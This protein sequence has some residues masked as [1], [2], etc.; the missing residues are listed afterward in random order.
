MKKRVKAVSIAMASVVACSVLLSACSSEGG[1]SAAFLSDNVVHASSMDKQ[2]SGNYA[3]GS[4]GT[5]E[6][7]NASQSFKL[8]L[9]GKEVVLKHAAIDR[10]GEQY[11]PINEVAEAIGATV[12]V[13]NTRSTITLTKGVRKHVLNDKG[14]KFP[15][16][17]GVK[18][19]PIG[20]IA[21]GLYTQ[22]RY[23][24][25]EGA[26]YLTSV[27]TGATSQPQG[28]TNNGSTNKPQNST[29]SNQVGSSVDKANVTFKLYVDGKEVDLKHAP[30][31]RNG[32]QYFAIDEIAELIGAKVTVDSKRSLITITKGVKKHVLN[33]K[34][35]KFPVIDGAKYAPINA[36]AGGLNTQIRHN[37]QDG[38]IYL[39]NM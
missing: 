11:F 15:V 6:K 16:V 19:A 4:N 8:F 13:D 25:Q 9:D 26:V 35:N 36:I 30:V 12:T 14:N 5:S 37:H 31:N 10:N 32:Q 22:I 24:H 7:S 27:N 28:S 21:G 39:Y 1:A 33:D 2:A 20:A 18:Y 17:D 38:I 3:G 23:N 29:G 34:G